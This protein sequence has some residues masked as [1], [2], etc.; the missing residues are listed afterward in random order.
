MG[1][2]EKGPVQKKRAENRENCTGYIL[3]KVKEN[4]G[5]I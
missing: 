5:T 2:D 3:E 1:R 4:S